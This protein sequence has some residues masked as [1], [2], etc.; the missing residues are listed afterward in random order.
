MTARRLSDLPA[1]ARLGIVLALVLLF[2]FYLA[3]QATLWVRDGGGR[4]PGPDAVLGKYHGRMDASRLHQ[5]L[6]L[7]DSDPRSMA[8]FLD[9]QG[10]PDVTEKR[11]RAVLGWVEAG[12][13]ESGWPPVQDI[14]HVEATCLNCHAP[15][16][17]KEDVPLETLEQV[18]RVAAR[19][20]G[21]GLSSLL[22]SAHNHIFSFAVLGLL[23]SLGLSWT[24]V[25]P[26]LGGLLVVAAFAGA[27]LDVGSWFLTRSYGAPW[28]YTVI[29]GGAL[30]GAATSAMAVLLLDELCLG[31]RGAR[32][33]RLGRP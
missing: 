19:G 30:F 5:V 1:L 15:G 18:R 2:G 33:L 23:L 12:T 32:A 28:Q 26:A 24:G 21:M 11:R 3:S 29:L 16:G 8:V 20:T 25:R 6:E 17:E 4:L 31:G 22:V 10:R 14:L 7:P 9:P 13:P 27:A